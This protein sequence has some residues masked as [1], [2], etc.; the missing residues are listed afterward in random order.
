M[1]QAMHAISLVIGG[2][3]MLSLV[4]L[5]FVYCLLCTLWVGA[6]MVAYHAVTC[7]AQTLVAISCC[8]C[9]YM[10]TLQQG[11]P[12]LCQVAHR[13]ERKEA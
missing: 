4:L 13:V 5:S 6:A 7:F 12:L 3:P 2:Q 10:P 11:K 9:Q 8:S 1:S